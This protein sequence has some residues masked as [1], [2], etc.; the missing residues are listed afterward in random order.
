M[1]NMQNSMVQDSNMQNSIVG[2]AFL[3][4]IGNTLFAKCGP[5]NQNFQFK[6]KFGAKNNLNM[7]NST[8]VFTFSVFYCTV[9]D[10]AFKCLPFLGKYG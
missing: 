7:Q 8:V 1:Q 5:K 4:T 2:F 6:L 3:F 9:R 10:C